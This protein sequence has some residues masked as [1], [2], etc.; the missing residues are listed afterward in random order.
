MG[1][2]TGSNHDIADN[3][4]II[5]QCLICIH[6][7]TYLYFHVCLFVCLFLYH[8]CFL[9]IG[10]EFYLGQLLLIGVILAFNFVI[11][12][13]VVYKITFR[14][15]MSGNERDKKKETIKRV[16]NAVIISVLL[17]LTW[18]F[19][20]LSIIEGATFVFQLIFCIA[21][22]LQGL[23]IFLLFCVRNEAVRKQWKRWILCS[24]GSR[25][26][27]YTSGGSHGTG[28]GTHSTAGDGGTIPMNK[29]GARH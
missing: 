15:N 16:Q 12:T 25:G 1:A 6:Y 13:M 7:C 28:T 23:F 3:Y 20:F 14:K 24:D 17:G 29:R 9:N 27:G 11:F 26:S 2:W 4:L 5:I 21:N 19:A 18:I 10:L 8:S 22:S